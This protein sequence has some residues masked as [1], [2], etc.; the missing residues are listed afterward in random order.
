MAIKAWRREVVRRVATSLGI[1]KSP[2]TLLSLSLRKRRIF[3]EGVIAGIKLYPELLEDELGDALLD[4]CQAVVPRRGRPAVDRRGLINRMAG[5][6]SEAS[7]QPGRPRK[8]PR[9]A[10]VHKA[11]TYMRRQDMRTKRIPR[12]AWE[13][14]A[15]LY[16]RGYSSHGVAMSPAELERKARRDAKRMYEDQ[17]SRKAIR[18]QAAVAL[19][20]AWKGVRGK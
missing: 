18:A 7:G 3:V 10:M 15:D 4:L 11:V 8:Y 19:S 6:P 5:E 17:P 13:Y 20:E 12:S 1:N 9:P 16:V 2:E 14:I